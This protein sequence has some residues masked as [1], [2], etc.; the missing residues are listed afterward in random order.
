MARDGKGWM[1]RQRT[2]VSA[3]ARR[4]LEE[5]REKDMNGQTTCGW[6]SGPRDAAIDV[7]VAKWWLAI[8]RGLL[9]SGI[10]RQQLLFRAP[11]GCRRLPSF[12]SPLRK[13]RAH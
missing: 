8:S 4:T 6:M 2:H 12:A 9:A 11:S 13:Q 3:D 10:R 5:A 1:H 7:P